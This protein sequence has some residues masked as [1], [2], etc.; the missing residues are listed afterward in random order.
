MGYNLIFLG[1]PGAGKGTQAKRVSSSLGVPQI[2]TGDMLR[3]ARKEGTPLGKEASRF[4]DSGKLVPDE[5]VIGIV[6]ERIVLPDCTA[7]FIL[8]GFPRTVAQAG[9]LDAMLVGLGRKLDHVVDLMVDDEELVGRLTARRTCGSCGRIYH[10][11]FDPPPKADACACGGNLVQREDD[12]EKTVRSRLEVY[13]AQTAPLQDYYGK[14]GLRRKV[15]GGGGRGPDA[16]FAAIREV[17]S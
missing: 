1:P 9:S 3:A 14:K 10:L 7:G 8:D 6:K 11:E 16:V 5:L 17:L 4:M 2:S 15:D 12:N 13:H